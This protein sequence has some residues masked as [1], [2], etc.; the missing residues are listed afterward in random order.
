[1]GSDDVGSVRGFGAAVPAVEDHA[2]LGRERIAQRFV[3][4]RLR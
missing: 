1:M 2:A 3:G 4:R